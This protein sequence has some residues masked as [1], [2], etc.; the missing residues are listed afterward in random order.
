LLLTC[1]CAVR[2]EPLA[3]RITGE[4]YTLKVEP[5]DWAVCIITPNHV[6]KGNLEVGEK[7]VR[8]EATEDHILSG[9]DV[10]ASRK[11]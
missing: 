1:S 3:L 8:I 10:M 2:A 9:I 4:T 5:L 11:I 6:A 7:G